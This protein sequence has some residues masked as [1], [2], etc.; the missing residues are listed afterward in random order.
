MT[1]T[2]GRLN[3]RYLVDRIDATYYRP[4][5]IANEL[6]LRNSGLEIV[7]LSSL[8][9]SGRRAVYFD[10]STLE[11]G[12][13]PTD[14]LP[15]L[16][17]D[18]FGADG[19]LLNLN[20]KR[21]VS[22]EFASRYPNGVLRA[23]ELLVKVKGPNQ[24][25]AY[26][27]RAPGR[28]VLVSG[29]IWGALVRCELVDPQYLVTSLSSTYAATA[30]TRLRTNLNV[31]FLSPTDL[32]SLEIPMPVSRDAQKYIG[33]K[34]RQ[35]ERLRECANRIDVA[36]ECALA[37]SLG[38]TP[39]KWVADCDAVGMWPTGG[40]ST[41]VSFGEIR[42]RIDP[43]GY[44]PELH[45]IGKHARSI[46]GLFKRL[47]DVA[48]IVTEKRK[49]IPSDADCTAYIS[50]LHVDERGGVDMTAATAHRP[51][52]DGRL[53]LTGDVLLSG[54][55]PAANRVGVCRDFAGDV[56]CSP[57][58]SILVPNHDIHPH[59]LAFVLRS[60]PKTSVM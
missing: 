8:V 9:K 10:T 56:A 48:S 1:A 57:E 46:T 18:D 7:P 24:I 38:T 2:F 47:P 15:F 19:F 35:A 54:I 29:T 4:E 6:R 20:A 41:R 37:S 45:A 14:W 30:R 16:T 42:G 50:I 12:A 23:N 49:R 40:F 13:A 17:A 26:N 58:F 32:V 53:C 36:A 51:G 60:K 3:A 52:S 39:S 28:G 59:Y 34:V 55:N 25:T 33:E 11:E 21:R 43:A 44:H 22:P 5:Y 31:E 27:E